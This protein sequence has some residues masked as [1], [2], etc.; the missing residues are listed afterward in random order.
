MKHLTCIALALSCASCQ[1][2]D[3]SVEFRDIIMRWAA[4]DSDDNFVG[5]L[6]SPE[7]DDILDH[8]DIFSD[9]SPAQ[10][11]LTLD[12]PAFGGGEYGF[13]IVSDG[14]FEG[15]VYGPM[16]PGGVLF[17]RPGCTGVAHQRIASYNGGG[18]VTKP[19]CTDEQI[20]ALRGQGQIV[21]HYPTEAEFDAKMADQW[22]L[23][24]GQIVL[25]TIGEYFLLPQDQAWPQMFTAVSMRLSGN[26]CV[27]IDVPIPACSVRLTDI[28]WTA[29]EPMP[30]PYSLAEVEVQ[31]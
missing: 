27:S 16:T 28:D 30:P 11:H 26:T 17:T 13:T 3:Q 12:D 19:H 24:A 5:W 2:D 10:V 1:A 22:P 4:F 9:G 15:S 18:P 14:A 8:A 7:P 29:P 31:P 20:D 6:A 23:A 21:M 25:S